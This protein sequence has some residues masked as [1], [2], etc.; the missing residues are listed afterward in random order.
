MKGR[1]GE[2]VDS[3]RGSSYMRPME[4]KGDVTVQMW[5]DARLLAT[6]MNW[7]DS[8]G[9]YP[10]FMSEVVKKTLTSAAEAIVEDDPSLLEDDTTTARRMLEN[11]FRV[12]LNKG[13]KGLK[14]KMHNTILSNMR[15]NERHEKEKRVQMRETERML[16]SGMSR[17]DIV[18]AK[19]DEREE[20]AQKPWNELSKEET[21]ARQVEIYKQL[22]EEDLQKQA[23]EQRERA[24]ASGQFVPDEPSAMRQDS[25][26]NNNINTNCQD[27]LVSV[28]SIIDS[29]DTDESDEERIER[30]REEVI[31]RDKERLELEDEVGESRESILEALAESG[32]IVTDDT[33]KEDRNEKE[34]SN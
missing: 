2:E 5:I 7:L 23:D 26:V 21:L 27:S 25:L 6:L 24:S 29:I 8:V 17:E 28:N 16:D 33:N 12:N 34:G 3:T 9:D 13:G 18:Q 10:R 11:R 32:S 14:N 4:F 1:H 19:I 20:R 22:E 15:K 30:K 31:K